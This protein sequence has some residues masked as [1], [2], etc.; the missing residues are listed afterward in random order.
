MVVGGRRDFFWKD[1]FYRLTLFYHVLRC[2]SVERFLFTLIDVMLRIQIVACCL[3]CWEHW[4]PTSTDMILQPPIQRGGWS[5]AC[6]GFCSNLKPHPQSKN[7]KTLKTRGFQ[8]FKSSPFF[9]C[10]HEVNSWVSL[11]SN[12][13]IFFLRP[14]RAFRMDEAESLEMPG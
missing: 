10:N 8:I 12:G 4:D 1:V 2:F 3:P 11:R 13:W 14:L 9:K 5:N 7:Q 6:C